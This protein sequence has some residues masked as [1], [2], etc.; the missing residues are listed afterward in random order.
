M[1]KWELENEVTAYVKLSFSEEGL[2]K[3]LPP[4]TML[5]INLNSKC[6]NTYNCYIHIG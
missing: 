2:N 4:S 3:R 5:K 1:S 6:T